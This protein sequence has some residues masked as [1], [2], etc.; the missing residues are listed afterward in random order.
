M[1]VSSA[2]NYGGD[3]LLT[4]STDKTVQIY[5]TQSGKQLH[6]FVGHGEKINSVTWSCTK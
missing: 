1:F 4:G 5:S 2:L 6:S 3:R